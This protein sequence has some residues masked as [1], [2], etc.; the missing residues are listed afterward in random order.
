[1]LLNLEVF[2]PRIQLH[3]S[4]KV[5]PVRHQVHSRLE[6]A[7]AEDGHGYLAQASLAVWLAHDDLHR[8]GWVLD[9]VAAEVDDS[10]LDRH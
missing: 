5:T 1:M 10:T 4:L 9:E 3:L 8:G 2:R 6:V 7:S